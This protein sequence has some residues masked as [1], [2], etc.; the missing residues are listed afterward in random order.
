MHHTI[1]VLKKMDLML[2]VLSSYQ[3]LKI[4]LALTFLKGYAGGRSKTYL[5]IQ[6]NKMNL[7]ERP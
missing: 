3:N 6:L 1:L 2:E 7:W 4:T 5:D